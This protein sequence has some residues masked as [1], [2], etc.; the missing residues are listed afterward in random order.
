MSQS[1]RRLSPA[2]PAAPAADNKTSSR[3][4][5]SGP[6]G[7][8]STTKQQPRQPTQATR[9]P[10]NAANA[11][12][13][14]NGNLAPAQPRSSTLHLGHNLNLNNLNL[15]IDHASRHPVPVLPNLSSL[16]NKDH[17]RKERPIAAG[18]TSSSTTAAGGDSASN[19][20]PSAS[21]PSPSA[22]SSSAANPSP[23]SALSSLA[24]QPPQP[25][26]STQQSTN[27]SSSTHPYASAAP[28]VG[29]SSTIDHHR[30]NNNKQQTSADDNKRMSAST[31]AAV[32]GSGPSGSKA[33]ASSSKAAATTKGSLQCQYPDCGKAFSRKVSPRASVLPSSRLCMQWR[34][35]LSRITSF[36]MQRTVRIM[37]GISS[38]LLEGKM[39]LEWNADTAT[40]NFFFLTTVPAPLLIAHYRPHTTDET[41]ANAL[42]IAAIRYSISPT[43]HEYPSFSLRSSPIPLPALTVLARG[44]API[45][46]TTMPM[47]YWASYEPAHRSC[48]TLGSR[49][50][51]VFS[52]LRS[53][54]R[55]ALRTLCFSDRRYDQQTPNRT[56]T[57]R[58][59]GGAS[60]ASTCSSAMSGETSA[61]T[62]GTRSGSSR[63]RTR[64]P[65]PPERPNWAR[66]RTERRP[67]LSHNPSLNPSHEWARVSHR[68]HR[69]AHSPSMASR[70]RRT[71]RQT[72]LA[73]RQSAM[74]RS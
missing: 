60:S 71:A 33:A 37:L 55:F 51:G 54:P 21:G 50:D 36:D 11:A 66:A 25:H 3:S 43:D 64:R 8:S 40:S 9:A 56:T 58:L 45:L 41:D 39:S 34:L 16:H 23:K 68:R 57:A 70:R 38:P 24:P 52:T 46:P 4:G 6:P 22:S 73:S 30:Q 48:L 47:A 1:L 2:P 19:T 13:A 74:G 72:A 28:A 27:P 49:G 31:A 29:G 67:S 15:K 14:G 65:R 20:K 61:T 53:R 12:A 62:S 69:I 35:T 59:V 32:N 26:P 18:T 17:N 5:P 10:A 42:W 7:G 63:G 44:G